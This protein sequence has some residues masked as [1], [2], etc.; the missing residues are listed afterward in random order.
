[1]SFD[2]LNECTTAE[3]GARSVDMLRSS[4]NRTAALGIKK[5]CT[6]TVGESIFAIRDGGEWTD[7][8]NGSSAADLVAEVDRLYVPPE[9]SDW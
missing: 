5:S 7:L 4:F 2:K 6:V 1:M 3:D 9:Y 8:R